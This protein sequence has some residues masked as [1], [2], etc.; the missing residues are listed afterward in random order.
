MNS[1]DQSSC[2]CTN[3]PGS[4]C[5]CGCQ[6]GACAGSACA[7]GCQGDATQALRA[8]AAACHCGSGCGCDAAEQGCLCRSALAVA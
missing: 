8:G 4:A 5:S 1:L 3:C 7:C 6:G 2:P